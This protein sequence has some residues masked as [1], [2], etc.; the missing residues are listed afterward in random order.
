MERSDDL[1]MSGLGK[2][3]ILVIFII[4]VVAGIRMFW[5]MFPGGRKNQNTIKELQ[6]LEAQFTEMVQNANIRWK[7]QNK[8]TRIGLAVVSEETGTLQESSVNMHY[9]GYPWF[10]NSRD[11][12]VRLWNA[13][14]RKPMLVGTT[15]VKADFYVGREVP[16]GEG[17]SNV[18]RYSI[19][20][21]DGFEYFVSTGQI[22][23]I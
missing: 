4:I 2:I 7:I 15:P 14:L 22:I 23:R 19:K 12:C 20:T 10:G 3:A 13:L 16:S 8:P 18:C 1:A 6:K 11:E 9:R 5:E 17:K 21:K